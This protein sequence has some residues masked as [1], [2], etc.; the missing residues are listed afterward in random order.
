MTKAF[1]SGFKKARLEMLPEDLQKGF[2]SV[3]NDEAALL[4]MFNKDVQRMK[5]FNGWTDEQIKS[6]QLPTLIING[7]NDVG[8]IEHAVEMY[9]NFPNAEIVILPGGHGEY[10]GTIE[11]LQNN[12]WQQTYIVGIIEEFLSK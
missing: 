9:R 8:T 10:L 5:N 11:S 3:N 7:N 2:L 6:I 4:N 1:W 12:D